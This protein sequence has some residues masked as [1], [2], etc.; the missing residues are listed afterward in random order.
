MHKGGKAIKLGFIIRMYNIGDCF[1]VVIIIII[2]QLL[3][4]LE[5]ISWTNRIPLLQSF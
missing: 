5:F 3:S 2:I 4:E 1:I